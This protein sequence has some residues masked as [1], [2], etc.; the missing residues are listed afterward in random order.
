MNCQVDMFPQ[1]GYDN[2]TVSKL[3]SKQRSQLPSYSFL[4]SKFASKFLPRLVCSNVMSEVRNMLKIVIINCQDWITTLRPRDMTTAVQTIALLRQKLFRWNWKIAMH[5]DHCD[6]CDRN[7]SLG[8]PIDSYWFKM[9]SFSCLVFIL[10][11]LFFLK[12]I[13]LYKDICSAWISPTSVEFFTS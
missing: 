6:I 3:L 5:D 11:L 13:K 8:K 12:M 1:P 10:C 2:V 4:L 9:S 7:I